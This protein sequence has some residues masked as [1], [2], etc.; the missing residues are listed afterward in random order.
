[1]R[2]VRW[3][4][5]MGHQHRTFASFLLAGLAALCLF[6]LFGSRAVQAQ[7][8]STYTVQ[9]GDT[10]GVIATRFGVDVTALAAANGIVDINLI[11]AGQVLVI[12]GADGQLP[13]TSA[14]PGESLD[15]VAARLGA[16]VE[17]VAALNQMETSIRL[18]PGQPVLIPPGAP[19]D[20]ALRF[21]A[22]EDV[23]LPSQIVQGHT[24]RLSVSSRRPVSLTVAWNG[25]PLAM[26]PLDA[27][28]GGNW[29]H[30]FLPTPA[31]LGP[32]AFP[33][34]I[35]YRAANGLAISRTFPVQVNAGVY[36]SQ[37]IEL[38][39]GK[40]GLLDPEFTRPE[41]EKLYALW[42][43][44][45]T[46]LRWTRPFSRPIG[47]EYVTTSPYGTRRSYNGGPYNSFHS[48]QDIGAPTGVTVTAPGDGI[49]VLAE[50]L[51]VRGNAV[52][53]DHGA[54]VYTG[55]WHL[56][57]SFVTPGQA[58][59]VGDPLGLVG[60]T[61][62]STGSHLHWELRIYGV[63]VDPFQFLQEGLGD[64]GAGG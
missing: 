19:G 35:G 4:K 32:G 50:P 10:L 56:S 22:I 6:G 28:V 17:Q 47:A 3:N 42:S 14:R 24:G 39:A 16:T 63:A 41:I 25:L 38:P 54:G 12:P 57:E 40:G 26:Q 13:A 60:T 9:P 1:M 58:V 64:W 48:G 27:S 36:D 61:G 5:P 18:F 23:R 59:S 33:L 11:A 7:T 51:N 20:R 55:Y 53:L 2:A 45:D 30:A 37:L 21:G 49:V 62:L 34:E 31:L 43:V 8:L 52:V 15:D 29:Q 46:P 44:A